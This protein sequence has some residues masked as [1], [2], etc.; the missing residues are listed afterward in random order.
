MI[1]LTDGVWDN[2][3]EAIRSADRAKAEGYTIIAIGF[4]SADWEF[5]RRISSSDSNAHFISVDEIV[6]SFSTIAQEIS[7]SGGMVL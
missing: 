1:I 2:P 3:K 4:G 5:L 7:S 6:S